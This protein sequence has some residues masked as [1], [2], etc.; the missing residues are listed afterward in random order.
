M[1]E[2]VRRF[3]DRRPCNIRHSPV[4][5][6]EDPLRFSL[7]VTARKY[8]A[9]PHI[10]EF[11][12]FA[13]WGGKRVLELGCGIGTDALE[14]ARHGAQVWGIDISPLSIIVARKRQAALGLTRATFWV[15]NIE[16][17][18]D[19]GKCSLAGPVDLVYAFGSI[20]HTPN[21]AAAVKVAYENLKPGGVFKLMLYHR[22]S[23]KVARILLKNW[24]LPIMAVLAGDP[25]WIFRGKSVD[26][27]VALESE[28]QGGCPITYT[29]TQ[30]AAR[31]L[32]E[33]CGFSVE[34][35]EVT[36]IFPYSIPHYTQH[37]YVKAWPWK[38]V[39]GPLFRWLES[40]LG[41][42]LLITARK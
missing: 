31:E 29:Y 20:H 34:K 10:P 9:E 23:T 35:M 15:G 1:S 16:V 42:H 25:G 3:W 32:L 7:Q 17:N 13:R 12:R 28:A 33:N 2:E 8:R 41:W 11:A 4:S 21:P 39:P 27:T 26:E 5:V 18:N 36:H 38:V 37:E 40:K 22:V 19:W 30:K 6:D 24:R 14:F